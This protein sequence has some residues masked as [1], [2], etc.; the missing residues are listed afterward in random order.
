MR[1]GVGALRNEDVPTFFGRLSLP[2]SSESVDYR[3]QPV[4]L[5]PV[6]MLARDDRHTVIPR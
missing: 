4:S 2:I 5:C 1:G 3:L 6:E